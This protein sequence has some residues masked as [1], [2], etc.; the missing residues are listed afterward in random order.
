MFGILAGA[1]L[2]ATN[3]VGDW[4]RVAIWL[5]AAMAI[6]GRLLCNMLDGMVAIEGGRKSR[7]GPIWNELPDRVADAAA[8]VGAGYA[9]GG[10]VWLGWLAA[11]MAMLTAYVRAIGASNGA[12][13]AFLGIMSKPKRMFCLTVAC[14]VA[15]VGFPDVALPVVLSL[16]VVGCLITCVQRLGWIEGRLPG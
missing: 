1:L 2:A 10:I 13:E 9:V 4:A 16:V 5:L 6:Q 14:L 11:V 15:A 12:G 8:L 3:L 7:T